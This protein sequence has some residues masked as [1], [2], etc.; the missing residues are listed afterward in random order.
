MPKGGFKELFVEAGGDRN[1]LVD[2][3]LDREMQ[4]TGKSAEEVAL[5]LTGHWLR[6]RGNALQALTES[7]ESQQIVQAAKESWH[8]GCKTSMSAQSI[9]LMMTIA[10]LYWE[11][12]SSSFFPFAGA[13]AV[14][15]AVL[16]T[17]TEGAQV[18]A[19]QLLEALFVARGVAT[20]LGRNILLDSTGQDCRYACGL[21]A[22]PAA[23]ALT[24]LSGGTAA[25]IHNAIVFSIQRCATFECLP[26]GEMVQLPCAARNATQA[27]GAVLSADRALEDEAAEVGVDQALLQLCTPGN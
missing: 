6:I 19:E 24:T 1:A 11:R 25:M 23:A 7:L 21:A 13:E 15:A 26:V 18:N 22:A 8:P 5:E 20:V 4:R 14:L 10:V 9:D 3:L 16:V 2:I 27:L 12:P 17:I